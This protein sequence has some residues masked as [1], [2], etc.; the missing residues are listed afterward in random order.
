[1]PSA[2]NLHLDAALTNFA[3]QY[4]QDSAIMIGDKV[5]PP[6]RVK[7]ESDKYFKYSQGNNI[8]IA[9]AYRADGAPAREIEWSLDTEGTYTAMEYSLKGIATDRAIK[10]A[11]R[12]IDVKKD[13]MFQLQDVI[14]LAREKRVAD[15]IFNGTT[16]SSY[17]ASLTGDDRWDVYTTSESDPVEDIETG[18]DSVM[19]NSL[20]R[21]NTVIMGYEVFKYLRHHPLIK[22]R[23]LYGG[24]NSDPA[25]INE[26]A[27][28]QIF[29]VDQVLVGRAQYNSAQQGQ[30][31]STSYVWGKYVMVA[32]I[33]P[34]PQQVKTVTLS[35]SP[36]SQ[37]MQ[38]KSWRNDERAGT[39]IEVGHVIDE[40]VP[41]TACGYL[42]QTVVS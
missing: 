29:D 10:N 12:P 4:R 27:L 38:T 13:T 17:T 25:S 16:F 19:S 41:C 7:K 2:N 6:V 35:M 42:L 36:E 40:I 32:Y 26:R 23:V 24:S 5:S 20:K 22:E 39:M 15:A 31:V 21:P 30:T 1:M 37:S 8:T 28:A 34:S 9:T 3:L 33:A 11:D 14:M 18:K